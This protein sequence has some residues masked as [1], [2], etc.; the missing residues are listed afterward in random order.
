M[1][2][3]EDPC[4]KCTEIMPHQKEYTNHFVDEANTMSDHKEM[5]INDCNHRSE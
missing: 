3:N 1:A 2:G 4:N 5:K